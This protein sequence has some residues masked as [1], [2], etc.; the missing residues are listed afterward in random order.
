MMA[1][2]ERKYVQILE[3]IIARQKQTIDE[4]IKISEAQATR[5]AELERRLNMNSSNSSKPPSSDGL[6]KKSRS[7]R[8]PSGKKPGG[9]HGHKGTTL[10]LPCSPSETIQCKPEKCS[11]CDRSAQCQGKAIESRFVIDVQINPVVREFLQMA[12]RCPKADGWLLGEFPSGVTATKQYGNALRALVVSLNTECAVSVNKIHNLLN[13]VL[14]LPVSTG[15]I[16][17]AVTSFASKQDNTMHSIQS[18]F[19]QLPVVNADET[20]MRAEEET[21]WLHNVSTDQWTYQYASKKRGKAGMAEAGFLP[22]Y[23]GIVV[24]DCWP[25]YWAFPVAG[26]GLC[27]AHILRELQGILDNTP[28]QEW[29]RNITELLV[30]MKEVKEKLLSKGKTGASYYYRHLFLDEWHRQICAGKAQNPIAEH[31]KR[32]KKNRARSLG[33]FGGAHGR[34]PLV[35]P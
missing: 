5:I 11:S 23:K 28:E 17:R 16:H 24:H 2:E 3:D 7:L 12:Y 4:L 25:S 8:K 31:E 34:I 18:N 26:H 30:R 29:A 27:L 15:F 14:H 33:S 6:K 35:L 21:A 19:L 20:G 9:Q 1:L 10:R 22:E 13:S 32:K